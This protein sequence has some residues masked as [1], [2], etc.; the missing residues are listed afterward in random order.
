VTCCCIEPK[1]ILAIHNTPRTMSHLLFECPR[2]VSDE[3]RNAGANALFGPVSTS[4][5][6]SE[7]STARVLVEADR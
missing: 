4:T 3:F 6:K 2:Y 1:H 5:R 7:D